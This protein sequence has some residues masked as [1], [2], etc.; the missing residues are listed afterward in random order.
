MGAA[1]DEPVQYQCVFGADAHPEMGQEAGGWTLT[2]LLRLWIQIQNC[3]LPPQTWG[4]INQ[5]TQFQGTLRH[6]L[7]LSAQI[8]IKDS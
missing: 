8:I 7:R 3:R 5:K 6:L 1:P 4:L 2:P